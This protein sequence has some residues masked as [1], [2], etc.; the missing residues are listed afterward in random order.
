MPKDMKPGPCWLLAGGRRVEDEFLDVG[1]KFELRFWG[2]VD[3]HVG[4]INF[5]ANDFKLVTMQ[6]FCILM[7]K[8]DVI[9][10]LQ[11][12]S[13]GYLHEMVIGVIDDT[14]ICKGCIE[15]VIDIVQ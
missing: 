11:E 5:E 6:L 15:S 1:Y 9:Q 10:N 8:V 7:Q 4:K 3:S 12:T 13:L 2:N 14:L